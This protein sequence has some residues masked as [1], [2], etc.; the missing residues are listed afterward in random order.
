VAGDGS[1]RA[2]EGSQALK[3]IGDRHGT[4]QQLGTGMEQH[5]GTGMALGAG[6]PRLGVVRWGHAWP[7]CQMEMQETPMETGA[8]KASNLTAVKKQTG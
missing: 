5:L 2:S 4:G 1:V 8:K 6:R 7:T 3:A